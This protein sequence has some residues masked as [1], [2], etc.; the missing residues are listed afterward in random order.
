VREAA[1]V[2]E[3]AA[4]GATDRSAGPTRSLGR[5]PD[6]RRDGPLG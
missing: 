1:E 3:Q 4:W 5:R 2:V 6:D